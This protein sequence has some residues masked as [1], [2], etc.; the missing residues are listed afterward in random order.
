MTARLS[1]RALSHV[2]LTIAVQLCYFHLS[3]GTANVFCFDGTS[4]SG[5]GTSSLLGVEDCCL[6]NPAGSYL[7]AGLL[8]CSNCYSIRLFSCKPSLCPGESTKCYCRIRNKASNVVWNFRATQ[9]LCRNN[10][11]DIPR[12]YN[13]SMGLACGNRLTAT[14]EDCIPGSKSCQNSVLTIIGDPIVD[15]VGIT[16]IDSNPAATPYEVGYSTITVSRPPGAPLITGVNLTDKQLILQ[17]STAASGAIPT[18]YNVTIVTSNATLSVLVDSNGQSSY[19]RTVDVAE[20]ILYDITIAALNCAGANQTTHRLF[21][22]S[23]SIGAT[24]VVD[25]YESVR[26]ELVWF[27]AMQTPSSYEVIVTANGTNITVKQELQC[28]ASMCVCVQQLTAFQSNYKIEILS[29]TRQGILIAKGIN[30]VE[31]SPEIAISKVQVQRNSTDTVVIG[32]YFQTPQVHHCLVCCGINGSSLGPSVFNVSTSNYANATVIL[33][34]LRTNLLYDCTAAAVGAVLA[35]CTSPIVGSVK[36]RFN[37]DTTRVP[38]ATPILSLDIGTLP[39][40]LL[41]TSLLV[42][43]ISLI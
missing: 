4:C 9:D 19:V 17:W 39:R 15:G 29:Y 21:N 33:S 11:I 13:M 20:S 32:C 8:D 27:N 3:G 35:N 1:L 5:N 24:I 23:R 25:P 40:P 36:L 28:R 26:L 42:C 34:G 43:L 7:P 37:L 2:W 12:A 18:S 22:L 30:S 16:C 38:E 14:M 41:I 6:R 31:Y 10:T